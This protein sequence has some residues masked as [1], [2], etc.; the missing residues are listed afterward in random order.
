MGV[1]LFD[2]EVKTAVSAGYLEFGPNPEIPEASV[3]H[4]KPMARFTTWRCSENRS[5]HD[6][7]FSPG[8]RMPTVEVYSVEEFLPRWLCGGSD[9]GKESETQG[10]KFSHGLDSGRS[11]LDEKK[12]SVC[13]LASEL[14]R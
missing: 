7:P 12:R 14:F 9:R 11:S 6:L 1:G 2:P 4:Q 5:V 10:S 3:G 8:N 13:A